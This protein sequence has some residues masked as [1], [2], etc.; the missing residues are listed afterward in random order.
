MMGTKSLVEVVGSAGVTAS[1][2]TFAD[3]DV[4]VMKVCHSMNHHRWRGRWLPGFALGY[5]V[6]VFLRNPVSPGGFRNSECHPARPSASPPHRLKPCGSEGVDTAGQ[7]RN[8]NAV[9]SQSEPDLGNS[10][11]FCRECRASPR[12]RNDLSGDRDEAGRRQVDGRQSGALAAAPTR[13]G[14]TYSNSSID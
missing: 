11:V 14:S 3:E 4:G 12:A 13:C 5:A 8:V 6:A 1:R 9:G 10:E 7:R 2:V